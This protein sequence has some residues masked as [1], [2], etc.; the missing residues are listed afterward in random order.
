MKTPAGPDIETIAALAAGALPHRSAVA[1]TWLLNTDRV[2]VASISTSISA[3]SI[4]IAFVLSLVIG[5][6][7]ARHD[8][9]FQWS[10]AISDFCTR[11]R[12]WRF[13][14]IGGRPGRDQRVICIGVLADDPHSHVATGI[15]EVPEDDRRSGTRLGMSPFEISPASNPLALR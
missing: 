15:R 3:T 7:A 9:V 8:R 10:L 2:L 6:W 11:F 14:L 13:A 4:G 12:H 5:V 1:M